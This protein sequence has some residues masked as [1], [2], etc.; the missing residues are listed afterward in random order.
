MQPLDA[1]FID[2]PQKLLDEHR[3]KG[4]ASELGRILTARQP[5][6]RGGRPRRRP[7]HRRLATSGRGPSSTPCA[8]RYHNE[9]PAKD[10]AWACRASTSRAT[11]STTT[12]CRTCSSC[13]ENTCVDPETARG[14]LGRRRHQQVGRHARDGRRLPRHPPRGGASSTARSRRRLKQLIVPVTGADGQAARPVQGRRL[15]RRRHPD[16]PR[17]RRR[18]LLR[19]HRRS[20]CCR[21]R[22]WGSTCGRC[23]SARRP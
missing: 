2:L 7:R 20:A 15:R 16:H 4:D 22:S 1:G 12:P 17:R 5:A 19:L 18:P 11:T 8:A 10:R 9:L 13:C 3:R 6:A 23:C 14:A 21:R